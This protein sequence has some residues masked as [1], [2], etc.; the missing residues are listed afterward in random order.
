[1][2]STFIAYDD[3]DFKLGEYFE[4]SHIDILAVIKI[5][6][7]ITSTSICGLD[8]TQGN[9]NAILSGLNG[10]RFIFIV[11]SHGN[12]DEFVSNEVFISATN[13][14]HF[15]NSFLYSTACSTGKN[16]SKILIANGCLSFIGYEEEIEVILDYAGIFY[17]CE[18]FGIKSF[19]ENDETIED[20]Y[21][22]MIGFYNDQID[23][24]VG[25]DIDELIAASSLVKNK[26]SLVILG[27]KTLTRNDFHFQ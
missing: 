10:G 16:L 6:A 2:I 13:A 7:I 19:L 15:T 18:N 25:G 3:N 1:M 20:S 21:N 8:C 9:I 11:L 27:N 17:S 4:E 23:Q 22:K 5:S 24:L 26:Q 12:S 14:H